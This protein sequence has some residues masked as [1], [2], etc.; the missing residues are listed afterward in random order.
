LK[1]HSK[2]DK[3]NERIAEIINDIVGNMW[4]FWTS[5]AFVL[6]L[7]LSHPPKINELLLDIENDLQLLLLAVNAVVGAKQINMLVRIIKHVEKEEKRIEEE[8]KKAV[9]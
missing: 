1:K 8:L 6:I 5:L 4:F 9:N 3:F 2:I 7:R